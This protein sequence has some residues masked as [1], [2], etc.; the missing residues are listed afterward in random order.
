MWQK[1]V[2]FFHRLD[3]EYF[4]LDPSEYEYLNLTS[5]RLINIT[6]IITA[7]A[8]GIIIAAIAAYYNKTVLGAAVRV[9]SKEKAY[10]ISSARTLDEL[11]IKRGKFFFERAI[12]NYTSLGKY[13][14]FSE[15]EETS[16]DP[17]TL[18]GARKTNKSNRRYYLPKEF[19]NTALLRYSE[20]GSD[21]K[22]MLLTVAT[23]VLITVLLVVFR[24][25]VAY[26]LNTVIGFFRNI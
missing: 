4:Y 1:T 5:N 7:L 24:R 17:N 22:Y 14:K 26:A 12:D 19:E 25:Q 2:S 13:V 21:L 6:L 3:S 23:V 10:D 20:K 9:L 16:A 11:K 8:I 18:K 15:S